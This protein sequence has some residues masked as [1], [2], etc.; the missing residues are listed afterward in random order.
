MIE[1]VLATHHIR[2]LLG[3]ILVIMNIA[4]ILSFPPLVINSVECSP[5]GASIACGVYSILSLK[6]VSYH[7]VNYWC[8]QYSNRYKKLSNAGSHLRRRSLNA[9]DFQKSVQ[10]GTICDNGNQLVEYP[11]NLNLVDLYYFIFAPTLCYELNFPR[12]ERIRKRFLTKR[13]LE[14]VSNIQ[15]LLILSILPLLVVLVAIGFGIDSAMDGPY[16]QQFVEALAR[17]ELFENVGTASQT[18]GQFLRSWTISINY[19]LIGSESCYLA[20]ILLLVLPL[21]SQH[22]CRNSTVFRSRI[23]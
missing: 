5:I 2:E 4:A 12:S 13:I 8:R 7:M 10:N 15:R 6:L 19:L 9:K 21:M 3:R 22:N 16:Y 14:I 11:S 1:R 23:L 17:N 18:C 20:H